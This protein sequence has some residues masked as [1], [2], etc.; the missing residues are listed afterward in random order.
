MVDWLTHESVLCP[1]FSWWFLPYALISLFLVLN[2][3]ITEKHEVKSSLSISPCHDQQ[4]TLSPAYTE[5]CIHRI[6]HHP[7]IYCFPLPASLS[8]LSRPCFTQFSPFAVLQVNQW[9]ESQLPSRL[10]PELPPAD[11][12]PPSTPPISHDHGLQL[13]LHTPSIT[14][15]NCILKLAPLRPPGLHHHAV[16]VHRHTCS[17]T[18]SK[19]IS[20]I[21]QLQPPSSHDHGLQVHLHS[22]LVTASKCISKLAWLRPRSASLSSLDHSVVK[23]WC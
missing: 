8:S 2:S 13:H 17:I 5:Y 21:T 1:K 14:T 11:W 23:R 22:H 18:A 9:I 16:Q 7:R 15:S 4:L 19:C 12:P 10:P 6:L 3:T 20:K